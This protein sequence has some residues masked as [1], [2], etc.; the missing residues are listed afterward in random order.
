MVG[1]KDAVKQ[2]CSDVAVL[3]ADA[4]V[5]AKLVKREECDR[6]TEIIAEE[7]LVRLCLKITR[8]EEAR[9]Y[10]RTT[11]ERPR[12]ELRANF[13]GAGPAAEPHAGRVG[14]S[15]HGSC[16]KEGT[17]RASPVRSSA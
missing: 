1:E 9:R 15:C 12:T 7:I 17:T 13:P 2:W 5:D 4:L 6:A 16:K 8:P 11:S 10:G 14:S 3:A